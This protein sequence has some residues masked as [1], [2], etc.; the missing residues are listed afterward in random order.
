ML[1]KIE[2]CGNHTL[3]RLAVGATDRLGAVR[4][5]FRIYGHS[6]SI[7]KL[8]RLIVDGQV[9]TKRE[10]AKMPEIACKLEQAS[11]VKAEKSVPFKPKSSLVKCSW[12]R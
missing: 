3:D 2:T 9:V 10:L 5:V 11:A 8:R 1:V 6:L 4:Q 12:H 7:F